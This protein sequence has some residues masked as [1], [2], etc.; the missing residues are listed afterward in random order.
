MKFLDWLSRAFPKP[1]AM[2]QFAQRLISDP[3][4]A[5][6]LDDMFKQRGE[7]LGQAN[8]A[9]A[10]ADHDIPRF[11]RNL[12]SPNELSQRIARIML[13][14]AGVRAQRALLAALDDPMCTW[15]TDKGASFGS[16]AERV[17]DWLWELECTELADKIG[18]LTEASESAAKQSAIRA[19]VARGTA[20]VLPL[21]IAHLSGLE[22][23]DARAVEQGADAAIRRGNAEP[24]FLR[25]LLE[26]AERNILHTTEKS[27][28]WAIT[29]F[30]EHGGDR[31]IRVLQSERLL[32]LA[33]DRNVHFVLD[34]LNQKGVVLPRSLL[35]SMI[36]K[37][38]KSEGQWPWE[39]V[40]ESAVANLASQDPAAARGV[41]EAG[42][43]SKS[44]PQR[45][46]SR[47]LI[48]KQDGL[49]RSLH[50]DPPPGYTLSKGDRDMLEK[51]LLVV[52]CTGQIGNGGLSQYFF[53]G[54]GDRW[55]QAVDALRFIGDDEAASALAKAARIVH[56]TGAAT[57][58]TER[59]KQY[60]ALS[61]QREAE[62]DTLHSILWSDRMELVELR[63]MQTHKEFYHRMLKA[64]RDAGLKDE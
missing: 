9:A 8:A 11:V 22:Q 47:E 45:S 46:A 19:C 21:A 6:Q 40:F 51:L 13:E 7:L 32:S 39:W 58:R 31:A 27:N 20:E 38:M 42:L 64:R 36:E 33:N 23:D 1:R 16:P 15:Q 52:E 26:W 59:Q 48:R 4:Y 43:H 53:N 55:P 29:I 14:K 60:A 50:I 35:T 54:S 61:E 62:L 25:G 18:H 44:A 41:A 5:A 57:D 28:K 3:G 63:F 17:C 49:P 24:V 30:V 10:P 37:S 34:A 56:P 2:K 12:M